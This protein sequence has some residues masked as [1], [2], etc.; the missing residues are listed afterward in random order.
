M[1]QDASKGPSTGQTSP[2][3]EKDKSKS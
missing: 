1:D 2:S 3:S